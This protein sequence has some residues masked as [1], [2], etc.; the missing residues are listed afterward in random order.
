MNRW[1]SG[2]S[3]GSVLLGYEVMLTKWL[4]WHP[5]LYQELLLKIIESPPSC[6]IRKQ[7]DIVMN[8]FGSVKVRQ[9]VIVITQ[10]LTNDPLLTT[11]WQNNFR[12]IVN[13]SKLLLPI[14]SS[15]CLWTCLI[16][17]KS[18]NCLLKFVNLVTMMFWW[19]YSL[20]S[21]ITLLYL[22]VAL[23]LEDV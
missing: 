7:W 12:R 3:F 8:S 15:S 1:S 17:W 4:L 11:L 13:W 23:D 5:H 10:V 20:V 18:M 21:R 6:D 19:H 2:S 22:R 14:L 9:I 16:R